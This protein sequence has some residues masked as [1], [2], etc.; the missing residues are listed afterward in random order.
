MGSRHDSI[1][2]LLFYLPRPPSLCSRPLIWTLL[3]PSR[4]RPKWGQG[5][6]ALLSSATSVYGKV[7]RGQRLKRKNGRSERTTTDNPPF[8]PFR[9]RKTDTGLSFGPYCRYW[10]CP[11]LHAP[12]PRILSPSSLLNCLFTR[13]LYLPF[14]QPIGFLPDQP[15]TKR[16]LEALPFAAL[17]GC[18]RI[19]AYQVR[20]EGGGVGSKRGEQKILEGVRYFDFSSTVSIF[21][22]FSPEFCLTRAHIVPFPPTSFHLSIVPSS[23]SLL[24]FLGFWALNLGRGVPGPSLS[25]PLCCH[26]ACRS[27][28]FPFF[29]PKGTDDERQ[30]NGGLDPHWGL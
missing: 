23:S 30:R 9:I 14:L 21:S 8:L 1:C 17:R 7:E 4:P 13:S 5:Q 28:V 16:K 10:S 3:Y 22:S 18:L 2:L 27:L 25:T 12:F 20:V 19:R 11:F 24:P 15:P 26:P 29:C 6:S